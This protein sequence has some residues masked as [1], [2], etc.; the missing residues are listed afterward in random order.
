M[1]LK[2]LIMI[3]SILLTACSEKMDYSTPA[4]TQIDSYTAQLKLCSNNNKIEPAAA[5]LKPANLAVPAPAPII[6]SDS[7]PL[8]NLEI[9]KT[10]IVL[11]DPAAKV[12]F[13]EYFSLTC[14]HCNYYHKNI[15]PDIRTKYV[16]TNKIAYVIREVVGNR[17]D[18]EASVLAR[19]SGNKDD[20]LKFI[21]VLLE[22]QENWISNNH[23]EVL[24]NIGQLGG[25]SPASYAAC[26]NNE[27]L[28]EILITNTKIAA[29]ASKVLATPSFFINDVQYSGSYSVKA[30]SEALEIALE[31]AK[32]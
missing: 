31:Q 13:I 15:F 22:H 24:T 7:P 4:Q 23:K 20:Y 27:Q 19:C 18:L 1:T 11:G 3:F 2:A 14:P 28:V 29:K 26:L 8:Q 12:V 16:D 5:S 21:E 30:I 6:T 17:L 9:N 32:Q 25:I 10:D